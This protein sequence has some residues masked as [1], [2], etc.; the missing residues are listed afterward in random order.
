[1]NGISES[2]IINY[3][4]HNREYLINLLDKFNNDHTKLPDN[5]S[6]LPF[7]YNDRI[8][9]IIFYTYDNKIYFLLKDKYISNAVDFINQKQGISSIYG[10]TFTV[11]KIIDKIKFKYTHYNDYYVMK[12]INDN[13][14]PYQNFHDDY[15]CVK[16]NSKYYHKLKKLQESY[17]LEEV[18]TDSNYYPINVEMKAFKQLLD[19]KLNYAVFL[20]KNNTAV[21]KANINAE[22]LD[23]AQIGGIYTIKDFRRKGLSCYCVSLLIDDIF[24]N[25]GKKTI[26]LFVNKKNQP[27]INLYMKLG[28]DFFYESSL[29]YF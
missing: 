15:Y 5:L 13:F 27:A 26:L 7:F 9:S 29:Y 24:K 16:C 10:D 11:N 28:F 8:E 12:L 20:K 23:A 22:Y 3:I 2:K 14:K 25:L 21:S 19:K 4:L 17:H 6:I 18:Y 1:M